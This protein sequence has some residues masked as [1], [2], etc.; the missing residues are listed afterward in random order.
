MTAD[1]A[2]KFGLIDS[3]VEKKNTRYSFVQLQL[4]KHILEFY[5]KLLIRYVR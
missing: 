3:V 2:K 1:E 4:D 5:I